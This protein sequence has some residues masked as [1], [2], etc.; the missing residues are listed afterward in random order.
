MD[1]SQ[2]TRLWLLLIGAMLTSPKE[3]RAKHMT[4]LAAS[5]VPVDLRDLWTALEK[6]NA[7]QGWAELG[8]FGVSNTG[9]PVQAI[10][11]VLQDAAMDRYAKQA[12]SALQY[13]RGLTADQLLNML[14]STAS[15]IR[16]R[17]AA[18]LL[19]TDKP[20]VQE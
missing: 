2:E 6:G 18:I 12:A 10:V 20:V 7:P 15:Q 17:Q 1:E 11:R 13:S 9:N 19:Q 14:E 3:A 16:A 5:D 4:A 8:K